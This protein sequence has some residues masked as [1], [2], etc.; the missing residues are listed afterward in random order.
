MTIVPARVK[1]A[2]TGD[3]ID[4]PFQRA[5]VNAVLTVG[6]SLDVEGIDG[7]AYYESGAER[8]GEAAGRLAVVEL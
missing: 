7:I 3:V 2:P 1:A 6:S 5:T 4:V 8:A